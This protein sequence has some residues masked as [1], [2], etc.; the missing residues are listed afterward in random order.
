MN[1]KKCNS[2]LNETDKFCTVCGAKIDNLDSNNQQVYN[3]LINDNNKIN[4]VSKKGL[5]SIILGII[6]LILSFIINILVFPIALVGL[7]FGIVDKKVAG[8]ILNS[9]ALFFSFIIVFVIGFDIMNIA[10]KINYFDGDGYSFSYDSNWSSVIVSSEEALS[11]TS[12]NNAIFLPIGKTSLSSTGCDFEEYSCQVK[13]Y[14]EF[15]DLWSQNLTQSS[16]YLYKDSNTFNL[17]KDDIYYSTF[18]YGK[19]SIDLRGKYY[20]LISSEKNVVLSF[21]FNS[22]ASDVEKM[23]EEV[24]EL[25]K[26]IIIEK[27]I[28]TSDSSSS[29]DN[30][31]YDDDLY[32]TLSS[33]NAWNRY[34]DLR[35]SDLGKLPNITG[36]FRILGDSEIYWEFK[37]DEFWFYKSVNDLNDN[38]WYGKI[39]FLTEKEELDSFG[40][41]ENK[42][43]SIIS[44]SKGSITE[45]DIYAMVLTPTKI[46][47]DG[48]DKSSTNIPE[49]AKWKRVWIIIDHDEEGIEAQVL[50]MDTN[51]TG[52]F[53]KVKD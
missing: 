21:M 27:N 47:S 5:V 1:C 9:I 37:N 22:D 23:N 13:I 24:L 2:I 16:L 11:Y 31:I 41:N 34:S 44:Y 29:L 15:Y 38:Y 43:N 49:N 6:S 25:L 3:N 36:G 48:E 52:Y 32:D 14:D 35:G 33:M 12:L 20:V 46:I 39:E 18:N 4:K 53:V 19:S 45:D 17:L 30:V 7:I 26:T 51:D 42:V 40:L 10:N 8:I 28:S 50:D